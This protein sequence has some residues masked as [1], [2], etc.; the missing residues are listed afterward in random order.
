MEV[1]LMGQPFSK[2]PKSPRNLDN[3]LGLYRPTLKNDGRDQNRDR[4]A[5]RTENRAEWPQP[6]PL[7]CPLPQA[8][9]QP[10]VFR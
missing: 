2:Y 8:R 1:G 3:G 6:T 5:V 4:R 7:P 9:T 10:Q